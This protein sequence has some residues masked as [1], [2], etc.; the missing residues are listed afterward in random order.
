MNGSTSV[1]LS[2]PMGFLVSQIHPNLCR[3]RRALMKAQRAKQRTLHKE[4]LKR[5]TELLKAIKDA[6]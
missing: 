4:G 3:I 1:W 6:L 2:V 5:D